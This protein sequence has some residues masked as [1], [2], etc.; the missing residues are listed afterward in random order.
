MKIMKNNIHSDGK[1]NH[2]RFFALIAVAVI[3]SMVVFFYD[4]GVSVAPTTVSE[5]SAESGSTISKS[6]QEEISLIIERP[7]GR[8]ST[9]RM[10]SVPSGTTAF[11][12]FSLG[13][14]NIEYEDYSFGKL[15]TSIDGVAQGGEEDKYWI[16][17]INGSLA[18]VGSDGYIVQPGD[19]I[20]WKYEKNIYK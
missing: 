1:I 7:D 3:I 14:I 10:S 19:E 2:K 20:T 4:R 5:P 17:Y 6:T 18:S 8:V 13:D 9:R 12:L 15:V 11:D 16:W